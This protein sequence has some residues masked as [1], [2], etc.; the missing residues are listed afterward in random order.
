MRSTI[1]TSLALLAA[2]TAA[3]ETP[4]GCFTRTY[5]DDHLAKNPAQIVRSMQVNIT[6]D[7]GDAGQVFADMGV[8]FANQGRIAGRK[9][10]GRFMDQFLICSDETRGFSCFVECDGGSF[11]VT[12]MTADSITIETSGLWVGN[13][14][15]CGGMEDIAEVPGQKMKYLLRVSDPLAC[16]WN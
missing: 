9:T 2:T 16:V 10:A 3:A 7:D 6:K 15:G 4:L 13:V 1:F 8:E 14:D 11:T 5:S 12:R